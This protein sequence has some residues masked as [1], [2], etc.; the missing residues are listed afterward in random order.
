[1]RFI[2]L[3]FLIGLLGFSCVKP[4]TKNP[5]PVIE[6]KE[7]YHM[8][9]SELTG[10]DTAVMVIG[11]EDGDGDIFVDNTSQGPNLIFIPFF[12]NPATDKF[13]IERDPITL[14]TFRITNTIK[15]PDNGYYKGKSI[16]GEIYIP[17]REYRL[18][19]QKKIIKFTGFVSDVKGH[20]SNIVASPVY[21]L[22][23]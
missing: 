8:Q 22:N 11:Y 6:Y 10:Q 9:K 20:K 13:E 14:D 23:Y 3:I 15:Q 1:M 5:V 16:K 21:T 2:L 19:D 4:R 7:M 12:Y 17:L 18:N